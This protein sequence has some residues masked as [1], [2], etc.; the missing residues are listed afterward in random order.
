M[1]QPTLVA[2]ERQKQNA[3]S[4]ERRQNAILTGST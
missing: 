4:R 1:I 2:L 3:V